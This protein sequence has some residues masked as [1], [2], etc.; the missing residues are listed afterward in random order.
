MFKKT[1]SPELTL[2][3]QQKKKK[4]EKAVGICR[5]NHTFAVLF[6]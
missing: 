3:E 1:K 4:G 2:F 6:G 5:K